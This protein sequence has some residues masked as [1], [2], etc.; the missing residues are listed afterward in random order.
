MPGDRL[1][2]GVAGGARK[3]VQRTAMIR[4]PILYNSREGGMGGSFRY[5]QRSSIMGRGIDQTHR[6]RSSS[7]LRLCSMLVPES[8]LGKIFMINACTYYQSLALVGY[9]TTVRLD[10]QSILF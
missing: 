10:S 5:Q 1:L 3:M 2:V 8:N 9:P 6:Q 4:A 7:R